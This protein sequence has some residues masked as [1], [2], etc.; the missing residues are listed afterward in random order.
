MLLLYQPYAFAVST[1]CFLGVVVG[2]HKDA[3]SICLF[4]FFD[5]YFVGFCRGSCATF[6]LCVFSLSFFFLS[7]TLSSHALVGKVLGYEFYVCSL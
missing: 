4:F 7:F 5:V 2:F 1:L 6:T 3:V